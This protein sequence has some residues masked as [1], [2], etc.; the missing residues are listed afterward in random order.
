MTKVMINFR[1]EDWIHECLLYSRQLSPIYFD[2]GGITVTLLFP[3]GKQMLED[4]PTG[5]DNLIPGSPVLQNDDLG[6]NCTQNALSVSQHIFHHPLCTE[7]S[8]ESQL[9]SKY[10]PDR[11]TIC[12]I[13]ERKCELLMDA[14]L[15]F[16]VSTELKRSRK[17]RRRFLKYLGK[18]YGFYTHDDEYDRMDF[19]DLQECEFL[20]IVYMVDITTVW[21]KQRLD[22]PWN[23]R[24]QCLVAKRQVLEEVMYWLSTLGGA[25]SSLGDYFES[26]AHVAGELSKQ[27]L[28]IA[29]ELGDPII[30]AKCWI[31]WAL[32]LLQRG[33]LRECK[34]V[35]RCQYEFAIRC[36]AHD[37]RL[38]NMCL[39]VWSRLQ[40]AYKLRKMKR[41]QAV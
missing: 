29:V 8:K 17:F 13:P 12:I 36:T 19:S 9:E 10:L 26:H 39:A 1:S 5:T 21:P 27:Q 7:P 41:R 35:V 11:L 20:S 2:E 40:Y 6:M 37:Q 24:L 23:R 15:S 28:Q 34:K 14:H 31:F 4:L 3:V 38:I 25:Y 30:A 16:C 32:S 33:H 18:R 22:Y